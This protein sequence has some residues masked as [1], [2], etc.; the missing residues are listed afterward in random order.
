VNWLV[1]SL[2]GDFISGGGS[3][4]GSLQA[5]FDNA[6]LAPHG[7]CLLWRPELIWL[8]VGSDALIAIA[9]FS[10]PF[11]LAL[12]VT[13]RTDVE[14]GWVFW[15]F[16]IFILACGTTHIFG[17]WTLFCPDYALEGVVKA[18]TAVASLATA[19]G[20]LPLLPKALSI[21]SPSQLRHANDALQLQIREREAAVTA[22][23]D[24]QE[25]RGRT[26]D[27]LR[28]LQKTE[29]I[30]LLTA[31][32]AHDFNNLL[33]VITGGLERAKRFAGEG[34]ELHRALEMAQA[35]T[36]RAALLTKRLLAFGRLQPLAPKV[37]NAQE[38][39]DLTVDTL[40][41]TLG[42][43]ARMVANLVP[44]PWSIMVDPH[45][46]QSAIVNLCLNSRD[47][48]PGGGNIVVSTR[49]V[50]KG[51]QLIANSDLPPGDY[52][53]ISVSDNGQG[54][55]TDV[56][57]RAFDPFFTT[58]PV[59]QGSGLGLSQVHGFARQ[60]GGTATIESVLG[61]G[62]TVRIFLP[63]AAVRVRQE[64]EPA[65]SSAAAVPLIQPI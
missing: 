20:L 33:T 45:E 49:N 36:G 34:P 60:S 56:V 57:G 53:E 64:S 44:E 26:E 2:V 11:V 19:I 32:I 40:Q 10:I 3:M 16:A 1:W 59:G 63:R 22:L 21:P 24:E 43:R 42:E 17:I 29:A 18:I 5:L 62:T 8:H 6:N 30:G 51:D 12:F 41:R 54:M 46:L 55:A 14:F 15:A 38:H 39:L 58:K 28:Q 50:P 27:K 35:G 23:Q 52:F 31:G 4:F 9:Y 65:Q 7:I 61:T 37:I 25:E 48:M 13:K 47:A